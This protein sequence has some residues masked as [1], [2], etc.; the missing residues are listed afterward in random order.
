MFC[1][2]MIFKAGNM[3]YSQHKWGSENETVYLS[4]NIVHVMQYYQ[5]H[6]F[7]GQRFTSDNT[8]NGNK[9]LLFFIIIWLTEL[10]SVME[11]QQWTSCC[12]K[13]PLN[14]ILLYYLLIFVCS[15]I[16]LTFL[17]FMLINVIWGST[18]GFRHLEDIVRSAWNPHFSNRTRH[19]LALHRNDSTNLY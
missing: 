11:P 9:Y 17:T 5:H 7:Y 15:D 1:V 19:Y 4:V 16:L 8:K 13:S 6:Q 12:S 3:T 10:H 18:E 2:K 14:T